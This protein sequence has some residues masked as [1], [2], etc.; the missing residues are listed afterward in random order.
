MRIKIYP[1]SKIYTENWKVIYVPDEDEYKLRDD[2]AHTIEWHRRITDR[3]GNPSTE[4][5]RIGGPALE[6][7]DG[8]EEW[9]EFGILHRIG[10]P[11]SIDVSN[12]GSADWCYRG[13]YI[14]CYKD[15]QF[16]T[17]CSDE[18]I[19]MFKLKYGEI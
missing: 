1:I 8:S 9:F 11:A 13:K 3:N 17:K 2:E 19:V 18:D 15:Y 7:D 4:I 5:H 14:L 10:G 12:G 16:L 6:C